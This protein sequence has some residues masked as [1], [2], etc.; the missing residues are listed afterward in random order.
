MYVL[1]TA[2][3]GMMNAQAENSP[4]HAKSAK[5]LVQQCRELVS[6]NFSRGATSGNFHGNI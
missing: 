4:R 3:I 6:K 1:N 5:H 2:E